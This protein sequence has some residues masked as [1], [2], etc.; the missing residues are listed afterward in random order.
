MPP[1]WTENVSTYTTE[2][3][4]QAQKDNREWHKQLRVKM[5]ALV[6]SKLAKQIGS[7]EYV[8]GR[9]LAS[10]EVAECRR[11]L[12]MLTDEIATRN[13]FRLSKSKQGLRSVAVPVTTV[14]AAAPA[15]G[16]NDLSAYQELAVTVPESGME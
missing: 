15:N 12:Q 3:V 4:I 16:Q 8:V 10:V 2:E 1:I 7:E 11:R 6:N 13:R 14:P 5:N 9:E